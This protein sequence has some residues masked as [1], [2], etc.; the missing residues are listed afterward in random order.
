M[1]KEK[2]KGSCFCGAVKLEVFGEPN[3]MGYCHCK[4]CASWSGTPIN[5]YVFWSIDKLEITK[6]SENI[7]E[8][9]KT[10]HSRRKFCVMCGGHIFKE[11]PSS[12]VVDV[13][14]MVLEDFDFNPTIHV[15]YGS[16]TIS[17]NDGLPK[18]K[19]LPKEYNGTG[20]II[21]E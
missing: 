14:A 1:S 8:Y 21:P 9:S 2:I 4:D 7:R 16:K 11:H 13:F 10:N 5:S 12:N 18:F 3:A 6:G 19:D 17:I 20:E 15:H